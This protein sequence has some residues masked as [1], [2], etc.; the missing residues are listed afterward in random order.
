MKFKE[1]QTKIKAIKGVEKLS[2]VRDNVIKLDLDSDLVILSACN[3]A[4]SSGKTN[5][6]ALS[7]LATS[8]FYSGAR[9]LLVTHWSIISETSVDLITDTFDYL[10]ETNGDLS[11]ALTK[12]K[13]KM[14]ENEKTSHPIYWAPYTL[15]GR[16][17][18][19]K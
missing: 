19:N 9:S 7:G 13:I 11:L 15:V 10:G 2:L 17:Q 16:S 14:M 4:S 6:E 3:T 18:I 12:A 5:S 1:L 8:F